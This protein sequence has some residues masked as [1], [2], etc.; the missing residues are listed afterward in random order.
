MSGKKVFRDSQPPVDK[1]GTM[2]D[3]DGSVAE[4]QVVTAGGDDCYPLLGLDAVNM[5]DIVPATAQ[6]HVGEDVVDGDER[7]PFAL[8][9][10][11]NDQL[12]AVGT[13]QFDGSRNR[14]GKQEY[15]QQRQKSGRRRVHGVITSYSIHYTKLYEVRPLIVT[16]GT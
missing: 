14:R 8:I 6:P 1:T 11:L 15:D 9:G 12:V 3:L 16:G 4:A 2:G 10:L 5:I 7:H 13:A